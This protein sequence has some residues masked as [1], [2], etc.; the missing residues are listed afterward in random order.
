[1]SDEGKSN[2]HLLFALALCTQR[3]VTFTPQ[4]YSPTCN[5]TLDCKAF[6]PRLAGAIQLEQH[7]QAKVAAWQIGSKPRRPQPPHDVIRPLHLDSQHYPMIMQTLIWRIEE[8]L[9]TQIHYPHTF[10]L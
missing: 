2:L 6:K 5:K 10:N 4:Q 1:M 7:N 9:H 8:S 3:R